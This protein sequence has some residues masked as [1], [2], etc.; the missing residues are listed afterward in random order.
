MDI[1]QAEAQQAEQ[2]ARPQKAIPIVE[3]TSIARFAKPATSEA[4]KTHNEA[5]AAYNLSIDA[6]EAERAD[7]AAAKFS[8]PKRIDEAV[9]CVAALQKKLLN[10]H[11]QGATLTAERIALAARIVADHGD[12]QTA[13]KSA[14]TAAT[15]KATQKAS[16]IFSEP[17][18]DRDAAVAALLRKAGV[19]EPP[20]LADLQCLDNTRNEQLHREAVERLGRA[21]LKLAGV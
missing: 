6:F 5:V 18:P 9:G 10:L 12:Y 15:E 4:V 1:L 3:V 11:V 13:G 17:G 21:I 19:S 8:P 16:A 2:A 20:W 14:L 7:F